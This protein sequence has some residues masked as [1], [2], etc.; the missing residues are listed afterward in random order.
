MKEKEADEGVRPTLE[1]LSEGKTEILE[2]DL[3]TFEYK[4]QQKTKFPSLDTA[5]GI[6][7]IPTRVKKLV[8]GED[9]VGEPHEQ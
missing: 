2:L 9:R 1:Q 6:D 3:D 5:K 4:P 8:W 7:D